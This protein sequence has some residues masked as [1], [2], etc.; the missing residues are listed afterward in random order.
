MMRISHETVIEL[1]N[2][3][4][5]ADDKIAESTTPAAKRCRDLLACAGLVVWDLRS[6]RDHVRGRAARKLVRC[7]RRVFEVTDDL[8]VL[9]LASAVISTFYKR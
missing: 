3:I 6:E 7:V 5:D 2:L 8:A 1:R 4:G 9:I